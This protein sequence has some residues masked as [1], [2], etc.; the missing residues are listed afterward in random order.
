MKMRNLGLAVLLLSGVALQAAAADIKVTLSGK[1][2]VPAVAS[3]ATGSGTI[4]VGD[5]K[6]V[7]GSI[8][9]SG[10][11]GVAAHIHEAGPGKNGPVAIPLMKS[12]KDEWRVPEGAKLTDVQYASYKAGNLYVN[13]HSDA[14]P[15]GEIRGQIKP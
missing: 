15:D 13:V 6:S 9:T 12:G 10:I 1:Q 3:E 8:K 7:K 11:V 2:E 4:S 5:D 14:H